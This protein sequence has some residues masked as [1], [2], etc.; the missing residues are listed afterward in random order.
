MTISSDMDFTILLLQVFRAS[1]ASSNMTTWPQTA[2]APGPSGVIEEE[3]G[4]QAEIE[5]KCDDTLTEQ[6]EYR[7]ADE[8]E[9]VPILG[10]DTSPVSEKASRERATN[11]TSSTAAR[12]GAQLI[13]HDSTITSS[14]PGLFILRCR[15]EKLRVHS[16]DNS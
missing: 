3:E 6:R 15:R 10:S 13:A 7:D 11:P 14:L 1:I 12:Y 2:S 16:A 4:R 9:D 5:N 8:A